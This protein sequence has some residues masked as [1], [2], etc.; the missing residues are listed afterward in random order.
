[1]LKLLSL[2]TIYSFIHFQQLKRVANTPNTMLRITVE[3]GGCSGFQYKFDLDRSINQDDK[4]V[5][6]TYHIQIWGHVHIM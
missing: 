1:M 2:D 4:S 3:G 6:I 5:Y